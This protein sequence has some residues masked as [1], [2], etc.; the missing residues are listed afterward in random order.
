MV[1]VVG[2][3][4]GSI[5]RRKWCDGLGAGGGGEAAAVWTRACVEEKTEVA[6]VLM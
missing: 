6:A 1:G 2:R 3:V 4:V 5:V